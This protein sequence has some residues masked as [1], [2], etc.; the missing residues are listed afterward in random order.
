MAIKPGWPPLPKHRFPDAV[1]FDRQT[2]R[3]ARRRLQSVVVPPFVPQH[4][5]RRRVEAL[6]QQNP[7]RIKQRLLRPPHQQPRA[8]IG[9]EYDWPY[10]E[11][12][13]L[14][15]VMTSAPSIRQPSNLRHQ[16]PSKEDDEFAR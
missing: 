1:I 9:V 6:G 10:D 7:A 2:S 5:R 3:S 15:A 4:H 12:P 11:W 8:K 13:T 16:S 14:Y